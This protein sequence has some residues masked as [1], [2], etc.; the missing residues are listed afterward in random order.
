MPI[1]RRRMLI[2]SLGGG[3]LLA[4]GAAAFSPR[5]PL[6]IRRSWA[7]GTDVTISVAAESSEH[8][9]RAL[10]AAFAE[11][12]TVERVM[13]LYRPDSQI[14][15]L[16]RDKVLTNPHPYL[17]TVLTE[18]AT[19]SRHTGGAF[20]ITVQP[21]WNLYSQ[22]SREGHAP[23][24]MEI[25]QALQAIDWRGVEFSARHV[26][27]RNPVEC[28]T[29]NGIAQGFA[30]DRAL[31]AL[32]SAGIT[33]GLVNA[34][35]IGSLGTKDTSRAWTA[36]VQHP[37]IPDAYSSVIALDGR[38]LATSG[39]YE[40]TFT[41]DFARHHLFDP[42][43]G[44]SPQELA[45]ASIVAP[46]GLQADALSTAA[47]ILG[48]ERTLAMVR[49]LPNVDAFLVLKTGSMVQTAGFPPTDPEQI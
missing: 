48:A 22:C 23:S 16:N 28:I 33:Q 49:Q 7:L 11:L 30:T 39:D 25:Q 31:A 46:D 24:A 37:R 47:M 13:S 21:L 14:C 38:S 4:A 35:E 45:S 42:Q 32:R 3:V 15:R 29:L 43:T 26:R 18:A 8:A 12:E 6:V 5:S 20:D 10:D 17:L 27:L 1:T 44:D 9:N 41:P 40:T 19:V 2:N 36:G 34:G